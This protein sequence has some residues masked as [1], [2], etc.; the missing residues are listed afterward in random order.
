MHIFIILQPSDVSSKLKPGVPKALLF[1]HVITGCDTVSCFYGKGKKTAVN[2]WNFFPEVTTAF[3]ALENTPLVVDDT[4]MAISVHFVVLLCDRSSAQ[5]A[6]NNARKQL[7]VK[8]GRHFDAIPPTR[9][10]PEHSK[11]A[12][13]KRDTSGNKL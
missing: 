4:Y 6:V 2:T 5:T 11:R 1:F 8:K 12:V 9:A 13:C 3:L 10:A 7:F